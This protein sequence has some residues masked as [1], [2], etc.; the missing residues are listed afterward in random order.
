MEI[1]CRWEKLENGK[2]GKHGGNIWKYGEW[3]YA[4]LKGV[5]ALADWV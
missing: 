3:K 2:C 5:L 4:F 1:F